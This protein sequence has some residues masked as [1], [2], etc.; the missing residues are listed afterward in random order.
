L[1]VT[2]TTEGAKETDELPDED[3]LT[4]QLPSRPAGD[5]SAVS[6]KV[7]YWS[8]E[9]RKTVFLVV[10]FARVH[11]RLG[12]RPVSVMRPVEFFVPAGQR[13]AGQQWI[14]ATMRTLSLAARHGISVPKVLENM[15]EVVWDNGPVRC[16]LVTKADGSKAPRMH[17]SDV[18]K[19]DGSKAPRMHD[20]EV[21]AI[22]FALQEILA[23]QGFLDENGR[24]APLDVLLGQTAAVEEEDLSEHRGDELSADGTTGVFHMSGKK[25]PECGAKALHKV[26]G[27]LRCANCN[28]LGSCG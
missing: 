16:G 6:S 7:E 27:C 9:G 3:P 25:C 13:D 10:S 26:D 22:G 20:S 15:R 28:F 1:S 19:A 11:G 5:L 8:V 2:S 14:S 12:G 18:T 21:A 23:R 4:K 24:L 17:D